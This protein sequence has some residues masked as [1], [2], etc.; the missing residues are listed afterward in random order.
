MI[1]HLDFETR[2]Q[3][4]LGKCGAWTYSMHPSTEILCIG[5]ALDDEEPRIVSRENITGYDLFEGNSTD[6]I[7]TVVAHNAFFEKC[8]WENILVKR[9]NQ[10]SLEFKKWE[11]TAARAATM[12]LPKAL[13]DIPKALGLEVRKDD[14]GHRVMMKMCK[15][16]KPTKNNPNKWHETEEDLQ[17]LYEYCKQDVETERELYKHLYRLSEKEQA[18]WELDQ[19]INMRGVCVDLELVDAAIDLIAENNELLNLELNALTSGLV[20]SV[21]KTAR[22][23][24]WLNEE[25]LEVKNV[26]KATVMG[27]L[28]DDGLADNVRRV[29]E[30]RQEVSKTSTAKYKALKNAAPDGRLRGSLAYHSASTGRWG[31][32]LF[33]P[34]NLPRGDVK[35]MDQACGIVKTKDIDWI[36]TCYPSLMNLLSGTVR[37]ALCASEGKKLLVVDYSS[38]E[39][40]VICWL[41]GQEDILDLYRKGEDLYVDMAKVI[42]GKQ[43]INDDERKLG[44]VAVLGASYQMGPAKFKD[45]CSNFGIEVSEA[46]A[47]RVIEAY[48]VRYS[49]VKAWWYKVDREAK[50]TCRSFHDKMHW[51]LEGDFLF[52]CLPSGRELLY[53]HPKIIEGQLT[54][55]GL[56]SV[57]RKYERQTTYGGKLAENITQAVARDIM[58]EAMLRLD[59]EGFKVVLT[60]HDE[61]I[62]EVWEDDHMSLDKMIRIMTTLP[63]WAEGL[64]LAASGWEGKRYK[65]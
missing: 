54:Y 33:Q 20:D 34:Q 43:D 12:G 24:A 30:I 53:R 10:P 32:R 19:E 60:V 49:K 2:S 7:T 9:F 26:N 63:S 8:I 61:I 25:G 5:F 4:D 51:M 18:V 50:G 65:K 27:L 58:A 40:R 46:M 14:A 13:K 41:A 3:V 36:E 47:K 23:L 59:A 38:I 62:C 44:K 21:T 29:L 17:K 28:K 57:T 37:G 55:M 39:A 42:Y 48:R 1:L 15:P 64:P 31:G 45:T 16:R 56:N 35:D 22:L 6:H 52:G 11:C